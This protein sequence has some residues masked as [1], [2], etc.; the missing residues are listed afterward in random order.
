M[1]PYLSL[2]V[3][4]ARCLRGLGTR[5]AC[6]SYCNNTVQHAW[7]MHSRIMY[8]KILCIAACDNIMA[9]A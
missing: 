3:W 7:N 5:L 1:Y 2:H 4:L 8:D 9:T 6:S